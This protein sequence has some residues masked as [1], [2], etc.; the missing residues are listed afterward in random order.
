MVDIKNDVAPV[1]GGAVAGGV[2]W[3]GKQFATDILSAFPRNR[4][5]PIAIAAYITSGKMNSKQYTQK[6]Q[7]MTLTE[8]GQSLI[9][10]STKNG[11]SSYFVQW[12]A[13]DSNVSKGVKLG[14]LLDINFY[15]KDG[16]FGGYFI[17]KSGEFSNTP[18]FFRKNLLKIAGRGALIGAAAVVLYKLIPSETIQKYKFW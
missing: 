10:K 4:M 12:P 1:A 16:S 18:S 2:L 13:K 7:E 3:V 15:C 11:Y 6:L 8:Q 17:R 5:S 14:K 9:C